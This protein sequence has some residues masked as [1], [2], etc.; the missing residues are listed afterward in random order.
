MNKPR[1]RARAASRGMGG[2]LLVFALLV[3]GCVVVGDGRHHDDGWYDE[4]WD[5]DDAPDGLDEVPATVTIDEGASIGAVEPG[6]GAGIFVE[7]GGDGRWRVQTTCDSLNSGYLCDYQLF[8]EASGLQLE[9]EESLERDDDVDDFEGELDLYFLT[10]ADF[11]GVSFS[12]DPGASVTLTA[13]LDGVSQPEFVY[14]IGDGI[15]NE[16]APTNPVTFLPN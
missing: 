13:Y 4:D 7:L 9:G 2:T 1:S 11:D 14:W 12:T 3:P 15:Q 8:L 10:D 16:G 6:V 5:D